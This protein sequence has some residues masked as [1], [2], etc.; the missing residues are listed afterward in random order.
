VAAARGPSRHGLLT[1]HFLRQF[2]ENDLISP[3]AD[4]SLMLA[5]VGA[6]LV[7]VTLCVSVIVSANYLLMGVL[8]PGQAAILSLNDKF[9]YLA[10]AM[11][12]TALVAASQWDA[13]AI[14]ARDAAILEPLP[15]AV[16][17]I[18]RA[19][20]SA[21]AL[22]GVGV[23][24]AVTA[25]PT[26]V[27]P[28]LLVF[29]LRQMSVVDLFALMA[30]HAVF[31]I[32]AAVFGYL[33]IVALREL[34]AAVLGPRWFA[35]V[36]PW[37]QCTVIVMLGGSL[38]LLPSATSRIGERAFDDWRRMTPP[39]WFLGAYEL[40]AGGLIADLPRTTMRQRQWFTDRVTTALYQQRRG[41][42][43]TFARRA[44]LAL[45]ATVALAVGAYLWNARRLPSL[46]PT[47]PAAFRRR[48]RIVTGV[49]NVTLLRDAA[50][51]GGF[52]FTLA[53]MW[54]SHTHR[55]T[56]AC[57]IAVGLAMAIVALS[58]ANITQGVTPRLLSIQPL[59]VGALLVGFRHAIR[60]PAELRANWGFRLA[61]RGRERAYIA[62]VKRAALVGLVVPAL[63]LLLPLFVFVLGP[64]L[65]L[66]NTAIGFAGA[67]VLLEALMVTYHKV[68]FTCTYMPSENMKALA[69]I[70]AILFLAG[71]SLFARL[72]HDA[73]VGSG[74]TRAT[75]ALLAIFLI[76]R[77]VS[78]KRKR[79]GAV[80]FDEAPVS[81]QRLGLDT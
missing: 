77:L 58:N 1:R 74:A 70:Y 16:A 24:I 55:L 60:V 28:L 30:T 13:L 19:K 72:Q 64:R 79:L 56:L 48:W 66:L 52:Y 26:V 15:V 67:I 6:G 49:A 63:L 2:L 69:P 51:Q 42:F 73:L 31:T 36:S 9:F 43:P 71:A 8:T 27:F 21:V 12:V 45:A 40:T 14:D 41:A 25:C 23:A 38:L 61:W 78:W 17:T 20:A 47:P 46:A 62:G 22:L 10:A 11:I 5:T 81:F 29:T 76:L 68:P 65:A 53:A 54:R 80:Q 44:V 35:R 32:A 7:S 57:A 50:T 59:L 34:L 4:R 3:D 33:S 39:L 37:A 75:L 18:R